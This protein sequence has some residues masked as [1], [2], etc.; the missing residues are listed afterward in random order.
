M[1]NDCIRGRRILVF[2]G[3]LACVVATSC[4][5]PRTSQR[6]SAADNLELEA[7]YRRFA[8][9]YPSADTATIVAM[10]EDSAAYLYGGRYI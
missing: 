5:S 3:T 1:V 4:G 8:A 10:Y 6:A 7:Q 2:V 9:A